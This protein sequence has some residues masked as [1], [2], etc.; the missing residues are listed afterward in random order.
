MTDNTDQYEI[1]LNPRQQGRFIKQWMDFHVACRKGEK[2]AFLMPEGEIMSPA[3]AKA[4]L[5]AHAER[6]YEQ[7]YDDRSLEADHEIEDAAN[8][9]LD[10]ILSELPRRFDNYIGI[11]M[12][13]YLNGHNAGVEEVRAIIEKHKSKPDGGKRG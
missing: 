1:M 6:S 4:R 5:A 11:S 9:V 3:L 7:G 8:E 13:D 2:I 10:K 12:K